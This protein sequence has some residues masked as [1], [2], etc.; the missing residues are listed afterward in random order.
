MYFGVFKRMFNYTQIAFLEGMY[1]HYFLLVP[2]GLDICLT[3][4]P[5][6]QGLEPD[7]L[8]QKWLALSMKCNRAIVVLFSPLQHGNMFRRSSRLT[9]KI[10]PLKGSAKYMETLNLIVVSLTFSKSFRGL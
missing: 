4:K 3:F 10:L 7:L 5:S 9:K 1:L 6:L 2:I 8:L